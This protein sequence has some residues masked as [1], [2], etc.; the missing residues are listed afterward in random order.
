MNLPARDS[1]GRFTSGAGFKPGSFSA[2]VTSFGQ[3][4]MDSVERI[5]RGVTLKLFGAVI[6]DTPVLSGRARGNWRVS[7]GKPVLDTLD[8]VDPTGAAVLA[9]VTSAVVASKGDTAM[10]LANSLP[11][12]ARLEYDGWSKKAPEGMVRRNVAR[13]NGLIKAEVAS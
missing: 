9:E 4:T 1:A 10:F 13:F 6:M 3:K 7:E 12:I 2:Q 5:R 8:R 11:Y